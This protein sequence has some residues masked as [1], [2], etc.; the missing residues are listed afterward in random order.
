MSL[1]IDTPTAAWAEQDLTLDG[2]KYVF[3]YSFNERDSRWRFDVTLAGTAVISGVK[4]M[5]NQFLLGHYVLADFDHGDIACVRF[6][7]DGLPVGRD[8]LGLTKPYSLVYFTNDELA[9]LEA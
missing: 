3:T 9:E 2:K 6:E 7:E 8:N 4:I 5:E 1:T